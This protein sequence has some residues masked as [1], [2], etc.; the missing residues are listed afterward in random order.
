M[1]Y[2]SWGVISRHAVDII[3]QYSPVLEVGAGNGYWAYEL[4]RHGVDI[5]ATDNYS[6]LVDDFE[7]LR[8]VIRGPL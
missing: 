7:P 5:V 8:F 6:D 1:R 4:A 3:K 2:Y